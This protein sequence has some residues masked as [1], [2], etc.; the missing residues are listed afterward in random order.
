MT[1]EKLELNKEYAWQDIIEA[2]P[3]MYAFISEPKFD[4]F[5]NITSGILVAVC[6]F[7]HR[8]ETASRIIID[9]KINC[10]VRRTTPN[11]Y[12]WCSIL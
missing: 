9:Q 11:K 7:A 8:E 3:D 6:D 10:I 4:S 12:S 2:Y 5:G 1:A